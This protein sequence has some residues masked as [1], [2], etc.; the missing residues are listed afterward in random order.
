MISCDIC[1]RKKDIHYLVGGLL[2]LGSRIIYH[3]PQS[4]DSVV[5]GFG[6]EGERI[7]LLM[8]TLA[9]VLVIGWGSFE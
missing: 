5:R 1:E 6:M 7:M 2:W 3:V 4:C 8:S 9:E